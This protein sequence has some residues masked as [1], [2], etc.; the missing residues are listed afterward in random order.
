MLGRIA[1]FEFRYQVTGPLFRSVAALFF[2]AAFADM[3]VFKLVTPGGGNV[4]FNSPHA[5]I[6]S[7]LVV[8]LMFVF[9]AAAFVSNVILRDDQTRFGALV[10]TS[11]I[12]KFDYVFGRF[13]G[14]FAVGAVIVV[15]VTLAA[16]LGT[17]M[18]FADRAMLGP[19]RLSGFAYGY[20][21]FALPNAF[22]ASAVVFALT[23]L[24]RSTAGTFVGVI[25]LLVLYLVGQRLMENQPQLADLRVLA[26]PFGMSAYMAASRY[27]TA[28]QLNAG[29]VPVSGLLVMS[30][31]L[32]VGLALASL[33]VTYRLFRF[34]EPAASTHSRHSRGQAARAA[35]G[36]PA[37]RTAVGALPSP[38]FGRT[39]AWRQF[40]A[41]AALEA[42]F[43]LRS[44]VFLILLALAFVTTLPALL[45]ASGWMGVPQYPLASIAVPVIEGSFATILIIIA[46]YY[47]GELV[48]RERERNVHG[49]VDATPLPAW[50]LMLPKMLGLALVLVATITVGAATGLL[51]QLVNSGV[52]PTPGRFLLWCVL[53]MG[54]D[55]VLMAILAVFVQTLSPSKHAGWAVMA[56]YIVLL[57][58]GP[59]AGLTHPMLLYGRVPP[60]PLTDMDGAGI[61]WKA[62]WWFRLFWVA[63]AA[64]LLVAAQA[65]WPRGSDRPLRE[66]LG[67]F[68]SRIAGRTRLVA[69]TAGAVAVLAGGWI[70]YNTLVLNAFDGGDPRPYLAAYE[71]RFFRY[72]SLP[73]PAVR[74]VELDVAL[75]PDRTRADV[76]GRY[77]LVNETPGPIDRI[78]VRLMDADV[79]FVSVDLPGARLE[80]DD[81]EFDYRI[82]RLD[83]PM[84][85]GEARWLAFGTRRAQGGFRAGGAEADIA[86]NGTDLN[87]LQ[88]T[89]R[90]GMSDVGLIEEPSVRREYGLPARA[91][92]PRLD[93]LAA[94]YATPGGDLDWTTSDITVSTRADQ[95]PLAPGRRVSE[96]VENGRRIVRFVSE[97]PIKNQ[98]AIQS[99]RFAV[100]RQVDDGVDYRVYF[101]PAHGWNVE[102][103]LR[104]MRASVAYYRRAFGPYPAEA[105]RIVE[106]PDAGGGQ[107]FPN[108]IA[109]GEAIFTMDLRDRTQIDMVSMLTAHEVAHQ[110]WGQQVLGAR[111]QGASLLYESL[112][113]Y[114][115]LMVLRQLEGEAMVRRYLRFQNDRYLSGRRAQVLQEQPLI[116]A[117]LDQDYVNYGKGALA[118]Y[119]LQQRIGE[120]AMNRALRRFVARYRFTV[121]PYPRS[122][123]LVAYL[124]QEA[125]TPQD[126]ALITDLFERITL[127]DLRAGA[128]TVRQ[129]SDGRFEV[130]V[131]VDATKRY[132][133]G[134]GEETEAPLDD[135]IEV[136]LF[137]ADPGD[138]AFAAKDVIR[139]ERRRLHSGR[140]RLRFLTDR[141]P[142]HAGVDPYNAYIDRDLRDNVA[143]VA[144]R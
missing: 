138:P 10:R 74:H 82:Y 114:S 30:R 2:A 113:Q 79:D 143:A 70:V 97:R 96:R 137:T 45:G 130:E 43:I 25:A 1:A 46:T 84:R 116:R 90:I 88:L 23:T 126:Q 60:V 33:A 124:R 64:L 142:T 69:A 106:R 135:L 63:I 20:G 92:F 102:R 87:S 58:F 41:R 8:S 105:L 55:A 134:L 111:M 61:A 127:Y 139:V 115:A 24:P 123:D 71:K 89:P 56:L 103:M 140:Q 48:W 19:N 99:G 38:R 50:A 13:L 76:R 125:K 21:V 136:G 49:I 141:R 119:L 51:A 65:L 110:W 66:R 108:T 42:R 122:V 31:L 83:T 101:D 73:Q 11:R 16:W 15:M 32:W 120:D 4:L 57:L 132:A 81:R 98:L 91:P 104:A 121:A 9:V 17:L 100:R 18:P 117:G 37:A 3:A 59:A 133:R 95:I 80:T 28:A 14:A 29:A 53:P 93:D 35:V 12:T 68:R 75:D 77:R 34:A 131:P 78:H 107:A 112:A 72:A 22:I 86:G 144:P 129:R 40:A 6:V 26:D 7:H 39:T 52:E 94:T 62:A 47:G 36:P 67:M 85:P 109:V 44:P 128:P 5:V 118:L 54:V 27:F